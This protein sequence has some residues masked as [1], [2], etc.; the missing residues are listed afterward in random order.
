M[1]EEATQEKTHINQVAQ[2]V[3]S[4]LKL[5]KLMESVVDILLE[6]R[7]FDAL[8]IQL[9]DETDQSL[10]FFKVYNPKMPSDRLPKWLGVPISIKK[11]NSATT[12]A[13]LN[14]KRLYYP[15]ITREKL[16]FDGDRTV[17]DICPFKSCLVMPLIFQDRCIGCVSL[18]GIEHQM[19]LSENDIEKFSRY[20]AP[21]AIAIHNARL[22]DA[23]EKAA[24]TG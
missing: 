20:V 8:T 9:L 23:L 13:A 18:F 1:L 10:N 11:Q 21:I 22:Y 3:N 6:V 12:Y 19:M 4:N 5:D 16:N 14:Q 2:I 24:G 15:D 17:Y 7:S